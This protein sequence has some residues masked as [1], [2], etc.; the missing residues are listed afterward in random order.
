[1]ARK[2]LK[3]LPKN[4]SENLKTELFLKQIGVGIE[5]TEEAV[6]KQAPVK[7]EAP[8]KKQEPV[9]KEEPAKKKKNK[10]KKVEED[11]EMDFLDQIIKKKKPKN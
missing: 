11:D 6:K 1:M 4:E 5:I 10:G 8:V 7:K 9:K 3:D 2:Y